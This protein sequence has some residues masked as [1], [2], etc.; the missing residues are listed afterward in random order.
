[1]TVSDEQI[2]Q[3]LQLGEDNNWVF[4]RIEFQ[5]ITP[6]SPKGGDLAD[7]LTAFANAD[8]GILLVGVDANGIIQGMSRNQL[9]AV[10]R[11][12]SDLCSD[13]IEPAL[14]IKIH[15]RIFTTEHSCL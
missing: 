14:R 12:L 10:N 2:R 4:K 1:M 9:A 3:Q 8:G 5:G 7:E 6:I 13:A 11:Q 15:H